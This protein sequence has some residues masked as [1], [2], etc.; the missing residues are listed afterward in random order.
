MKL[1]RG[2]RIVLTYALIPII[3]ISFEGHTQAN[4]LKNTVKENREKIGEVR[5]F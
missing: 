4:K 3:C 5:G 2:K 1:I